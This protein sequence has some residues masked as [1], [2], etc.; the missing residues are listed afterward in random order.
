MYSN[1]KRSNEDPDKK[2]EIKKPN[3]I[4]RK[5]KS[6]IDLFPPLAQKSKGQKI[7]IFFQKL[8]YL[9]QNPFLTM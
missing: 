9:G 8:A 1:K 5:S 3:I 6:Q 2:K 7:N 4:L